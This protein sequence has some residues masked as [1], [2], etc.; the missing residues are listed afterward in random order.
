MNDIYYNPLI[1]IIVYHHLVFI[2][3]NTALYENMME[4]VDRT[5]F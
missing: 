3:G 2:F 5:W 1:I 4:A